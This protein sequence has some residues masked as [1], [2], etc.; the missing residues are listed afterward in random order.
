MR[1][2]ASKKSFWKVLEIGV[3]KVPKRVLRS[4]LAVDFGR[5]FLKRVLGMG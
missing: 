5:R 2:Y 4:C 1:Q 3:E